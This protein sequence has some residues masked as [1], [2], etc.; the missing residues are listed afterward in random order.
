LYVPPDEPDEPDEEAE[1]PD[2]ASAD[3][4]LELHAATDITIAE[5]TPAIAVNLPRI[6]SPCLPGRERPARRSLDTNLLQLKPASSISYN[7]H[8]NL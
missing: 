1:E 5:Q 3:D 2:E 4:P 8:L 6:A 7:N